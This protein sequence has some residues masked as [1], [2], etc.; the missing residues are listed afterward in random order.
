MLTVCGID[1]GF[2]G[3]FCIIK[4][5]E[6][7]SDA[8]VAFFPMP[9]KKIKDKKVLD[10]LEINTILKNFQLDLTYLESVH[11]LPKQGVCSM[12]N[13]GVGFGILQ[14]ILGTR[15][16]NYEFITPQSW[17]NTLMTKEVRELGK[18]SSIITSERL[19]DE[20]NW[21]V[22]LPIAP[23]SKKVLNGATDAFCLAYLALLKIK[24]NT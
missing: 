17:K 11:A 8:K 15:G 14:G 1:P 20:R 2:E 12:F 23:R 19:I 21:E 22:S 13:F 7:L 6:T 24:G 18:D 4:S 16:I 3:F 5:P 10:I 9:V